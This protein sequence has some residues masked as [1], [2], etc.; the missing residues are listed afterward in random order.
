MAR[1]SRC[2]RDEYSMLNV[3]DRKRD[4]W[5]CF[6]TANTDSE[7]RH[8]AQTLFLVFGTQHPEFVAVLHDLGQHSST[9]EDH[10]FSARRVFNP[11]LEFLR[12]QME[13]R[14]VNVVPLPYEVIRRSRE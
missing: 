10:V 1:L 6:L 9:E 5:F 11:D 7:F 3:E 12:I 13:H 4:R 2:S 8:D 14:K